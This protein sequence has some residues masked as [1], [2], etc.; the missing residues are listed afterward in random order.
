[1]NR[2]EPARAAL[3]AHARTTLLAS[4][5]AQGSRLPSRLRNLKGDLSQSERVARRGMV[6]VVDRYDPL[7]R[8]AVWFTFVLWNGNSYQGDM[9]GQR[10]VRARGRPMAG[11]TAI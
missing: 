1:M 8:K 11:G 5:R 4:G 9:P 6:S 7:Y 2:P 3:L 10:V